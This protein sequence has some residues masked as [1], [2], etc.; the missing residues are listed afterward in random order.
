MSTNEHAKEL[1]HAILGENNGR[2]PSM[3]KLW[4]A[5]N[6]RLLE[7]R[8]WSIGW[9]TLVRLLRSDVSIAV[10]RNGKRR[11]MVILKSGVSSLQMHMIY[12]HSSR[13]GSNSWSPYDPNY[14]PRGSVIYPNGLP[15]PIEVIMYPLPFSV[16]TG[17]SQTLPTSKKF[18]SNRSLP[19]KCLATGV[20]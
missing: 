4:E 8:D 10:R 17:F 1:I 6:A 18:V 12:H 5:V 7:D 9:P 20:R 3:S 16:P 13:S 14:W 15:D 19:R 2:V 11:K